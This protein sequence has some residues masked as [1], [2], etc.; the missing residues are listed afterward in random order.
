MFLL[1]KVER[2]K[3]LNIRDAMQ[4]NN[5][6]EDKV[7]N[8]IITVNAKLKYNTF[9]YPSSIFFLSSLSLSISFSLVPSIYFS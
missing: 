3:K 6:S 1:Y 2:L 5:I 9:L 4:N 7:Q 8:K